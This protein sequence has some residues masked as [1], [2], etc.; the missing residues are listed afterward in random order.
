[1]GDTSKPTGFEALVMALIGGSPVDHGNVND[2]LRSIDNN[3]RRCADALE[4]LV[5]VAHTKR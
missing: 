2:T 4:T 5:N 3:L 1:M